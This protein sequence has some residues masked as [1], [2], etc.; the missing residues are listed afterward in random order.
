VRSVT[1]DGSRDRLDFDHKYLEIHMIARRWTVL[2][3][4]P[5]LGGGG[6]EHVTELLARHLSQ[7]KYDIHLGL[8]TETR[9]SARSLPEHVVVHG[10]GACRVRYAG[11]RLVRLI[12]RMRPDVVLCSMAHLNF[13]LLLLRPLLPVKTHILVRQNGMASAMLASAGAPRLRRWLYRFCYARADR[14]ICQSQAMREDLGKLAG[15]SDFAMTVLPNPVD[16]EGIRRAKKQQI[17]AWTDAG[18][19]LLAVGR[20]SREKGLDLLLEAFAEVRQDFAGA[21]LA[22]AGAG[23]EEAMLR[24][25]TRTLG[26]DG[27]VRFLGHVDSAARLLGEASLFVVASRHEGM[28]NAVLEAAAAGLPIVAVPAMGG[29]AELLQGKPGVW[30]ARE[31]S[32]DALARTLHSALTM[33]RPGER[34]AH[35]WVEGFGLA[36][37]IPA[38]EELISETIGEE[39]A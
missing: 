5:H 13:L 23:P 10:L 39:F 22:I 12:W 7:K 35:G 20:L 8:V 24:A 1:R 32:A 9:G 37:A 19:H 26:I 29:L 33:L 11:L 15:V 21:D 36:S 31:V 3:L 2:L 34:F 30:M 28:P 27:A 17:E 38:Y 4:I 6:A 16:L 25:Q 18:P 14:V